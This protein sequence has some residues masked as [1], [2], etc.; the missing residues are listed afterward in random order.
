MTSDGNPDA[1]VPAQAPAARVCA[2][3]GQP[4]PPTAKFCPECGARAP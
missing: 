3:C 4:L 1:T 2:G